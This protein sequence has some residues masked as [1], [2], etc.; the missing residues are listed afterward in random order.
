MK[1]TLFDVV[2][3]PIRTSR[4]LM[5]MMKQIELKPEF[6]KQAVPVT[7]HSEFLVLHTTVLMP[8]A[9]FNMVRDS[10]VAVTTESYSPMTFSRKKDQSLNTS[11]VSYENAVCMLVQERMEK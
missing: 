11:S 5:R 3:R 2:F 7:K 6:G 9:V 8:A 4:A 10:L 1:I